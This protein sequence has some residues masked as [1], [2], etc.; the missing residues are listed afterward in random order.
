M[1]GLGL[2]MVFIQGGAIGPLTRRFGE[3]KLLGWGYVLGIAGLVFFVYSPNLALALCFLGFLSVSRALLHP[4][5]SSLASR[6]TAPEIRGA[7]MGA[8]HSASSLARVLGP[9][10]AG[11]AYEW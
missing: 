4:S 8:F 5:L 1:G 7:T 10:I 2:V 9:V 3:S 6:G 11:A